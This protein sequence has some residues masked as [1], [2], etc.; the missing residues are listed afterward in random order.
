MNLIQVD[1]QKNQISD[2]VKMQKTMASLKNIQML[3]IQDNC[4]I[5]EAKLNS[6]ILE[7][8]TSLKELNGVDQKFLKNQKES[9]N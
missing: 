9:K 5:E 4:F 6:I 2:D 8:C 1:L 7:M 3:N